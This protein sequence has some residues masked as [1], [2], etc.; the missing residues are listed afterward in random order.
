M[1]GWKL[2]LFGI[3]RLTE[4][5]QPVNIERRRSMALLAYLAV[6]RQTH[7]RDLMAAL[8]WP[9]SDHASAR[10]GLRRELHNLKKA[11]P[12][13]MLDTSDLQVS[14]A[15]SAQLWVDVQVFEDL[16]EQV[17]EH[18]H[19]STPQPTDE[20]CPSCL[21]L[22][23]EA[24][25][26]YRADFMAGFS[27]SDSAA[28]D[29]WQFFQG[30]QS[31][32]LLAQALQMLSGWH[33][34][35][36]NYAS[37]IEYSRR[38]L[39]LDN[40]H[41][42]A[43]RELMQVYY[44]SGQQSAAMRQYHECLRLLE[45]QLGVEPE[46]E[47]SQLFQA[48]QSRQL[49][50]PSLASAAVAEPKE[51]P[52]PPVFI[53]KHN[54]PAAL[55]PILGRENDLAALTAILT[56]DQ[57]GRLLTLIGPGGSGKTRLSLETARLL[58]EASSPIFTDG[59][60]FVN[61]APLSESNA[62]LPAIS[63][64]LG[65]SISGNLAER[66]GQLLDYLHSKK[67]LLLLDNIEH[68][69]D[70]LSLELIN[71]LLSASPGTRILVTSRTRLNLR[72]ERLY[73][74][75]GLAVPP[76]STILF[77][78]SP[79]EALFDYGALKLFQTC[80][81]RLR[82][83][84]QINSN[85]Y[86]AVGRICRLVQ[87][88]PLGIELASAWIELL[89]PEEIASEIERGLDF[90][91]TSWDDIPERQR[92]LRAVFESSWKLLG[93]EERRGI[94]ALAVFQGSF[95]HQAAGEVTN[96]PLTMLRTLLNKSWLQ[97]ANS[98]AAQGE[99]YQIHELLRQYAAEM[100]QS[101]QA[102]YYRAKDR[103]L[104]YY[105]FFL[106][107]QTQIMR[108][109]QQKQAFQ[110][111]EMEFENI[112]AAWS[113]G[114]HRL[115]FDTLIIEMLPALYLFC[116]AR[117][118]AEELL[119][120]VELARREIEK[121]PREERD[122]SLISILQTV[123]A[124]FFK[125]LYPVRFE[126]YGL[127][128]PGEL[129]ALQQ[130]W[131]K[132]GTLPTLA[133]GGFWGILLAYLYGRIV[134]P[135][136]GAEYLRQ[137]APMF[138]AKDQYWEQAL[139]LYFLGNLLEVIITKEPGDQSKLAEAELCLSTALSIFTDLGDEREAGNTERSIGNLRGIERNLMAAIQHWQAA[140]RQLL[141]AGEADLA[142]DISTQIGDAH[143]DLGEFAEAFYCYRAVREFYEQRGNKRLA[144]Y[145]MSKESYEL[146][147]YG[148][149]EEAIQLRE[150]ALHITTALGDD[151]GEAWNKWEM[152]EAYRV[153]GDYPTARHWFEQ[154]FSIFQKVQE[155]IGVMFY[156]RGLGDLALT[157]GDY[158]A[159]KTHFESS[160]Q[161]A[162]DLEHDWMISYTLSGLSRAEIGLGE[163]A[164]AEAH[165]KEAV[166]AAVKNGQIGV[167]L[168]ALSATAEL[169]TASG[170]LERAL[171]LA[172]LV[173]NHFASWNEVRARAEDL[174]TT[175][176][177]LASHSAGI[178]TLQDPWQVAAQIIKAER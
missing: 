65:L 61:L 131:S 12:G 158:L 85:N 152:G 145:R 34:R 168:L 60:W 58:A 155:P 105:G 6:T 123:K 74:L 52:S 39:A 10:G 54:L 135:V 49:S 91:E 27:L 11:L 107:Q 80:A 102:A 129:D 18:G 4:N 35:L 38:W 176:S 126:T 20:V 26:L 82:P 151:Y 156:H 78:K 9:E 172:S 116:E 59:V 71:A 56:E 19:F 21:P 154:A 144:A 83:G 77:D 46:A 174:L 73:P 125:D 150:K 171:Q 64:A 94:A 133:A 70:P 166:S 14:L 90:L 92:S 140:Q 25:S 132:M 160:F 163:H 142:V 173:K 37:A 67:L 178:R 104:R 122:A 36:G 170:K 55:T 110:V 17:R 164:M 98:A 22:L 62:I 41:E 47:T 69:I 51:E 143:L 112:R 53:A 115:A 31:R 5:G 106:T 161:G 167:L 99:R 89:S 175:L 149:L 81:A 141:A 40:L 100:L 8:F 3:P 97:R 137:L 147:R 95:T 109:P 139:S 138:E 15:P 136:K 44:F 113:W 96:E 2:F 117:V 87:G 121:L 28:F 111:V 63:Q 146:V 119:G 24:V 29:D 75:E 45:E 108:G 1:G 127:L 159:A 130:A 66:Q 16:L 101:D 169:Y 118:R 57:D 93:D 162:A 128:I 124:A 103:H 134:A 177:Q 120:M 32:E 157:E 68:L 13:S 76:E 153:K 88:M 84:F 43:H 72:S 165:L 7:S 148:D 30:E 33:A 23:E 48:I 42:P 86:L 114:V 79:S 50:R